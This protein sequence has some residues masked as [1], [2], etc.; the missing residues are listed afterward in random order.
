M[1]R[2]RLDPDHVQMHTGTLLC[3]WLAISGYRTAQPCTLVLG[4]RHSTCFQPLPGSSGMSSTCPFQNQETVDAG[5]D[6]ITRKQT[7]PCFSLNSGQLQGIC[8][9]S[10]GTPTLQ[11]PCL[12]TLGYLGSWGYCGDV[13]T[14]RTSDTILALT[15]TGCLACQSHLFPQNHS[16]LLPHLLPPPDSQGRSSTCPCPHC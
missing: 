14:T 16:S 12:L 1:L 10:Q 5:Q 9:F 8:A 4:M 6:A 13:G 7:A 15:N 11:V 3:L 2:E